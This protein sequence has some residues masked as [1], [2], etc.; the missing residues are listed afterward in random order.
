MASRASSADSAPR[1]E[2]EQRVR[3]LLRDLRVDTGDVVLF[4][5]KC[6]SMGLYGGAI[7]V[8]AKFFGR[9]Q[10]DHNGVVVRA[11]S[12]APAAAGPED[13]LFVLEAALT[14]VKLR[15]LVARVLLSRGH[16]VAVRKL[17]VERSPELQH[18][19]LQFAIG[20]LNAPYEDN[21]ARFFNAGVSVPTRIARERIFA[22]LVATKKELARLD[23]EL[24]HRDK[25]PAF[26]R[27]A[28]LQEHEAVNERYHALGAELRGRERSVFE[29]A[30][31]EG[32]QVKTTK[33][34]CSQLVAGLYQHLGL[35]LP[36]PSANSYLPKHFSARDGGDFLKLQQGASFLPEI[37][38]RQ[39]LEKETNKYATRTL[40][41]T[42]RAPRAGR[43]T[44]AIVHCLR[45]HQLFHTLSEPELLATASQF[46]RRVL[47]KGEVVFYQGAPGDCFYI[48][49][50]GDCDVF[51]DYDHLL[52]TQT[53]LHAAD[54]DNAPNPELHRRMMLRKRK[55]IAL[56][57]FKSSSSLVGKNE[58]V[59]VATNGP[60]N[61]FGESALIYDTPRRAT[62]QASASNSGDEDEAVVLWQLDKRT[63]REILACHPGSQQ[64]LEERRFLLEALED[65]PLFTELDDRAK[66]LA[67]RKCFPLSVRAGTTILRQ[68]DPGDYFYLV[69][70]G[71][72]E[73]S[74]RKPKATKPFVDRVIGRGASFGE[75]ALLYNSRRGAS[76]KAL[77]DAKIWCMDRASFLTITRSGSTALHKLFR[78]VGTTVVSGSN[79]SFATER[80]LRRMLTDPQQMQL[81]R[82]SANEDEDMDEKGEQPALHHAPLPSPQAY[83]RAVQLALSLLL[84]DSSGLVN[85]SQF[86]H[87]HIALGAANIDQLLP[88]AA[89]RVLKSVTDSYDGVNT[90]IPT[91]S[92]SLFDQDDTDQAVIKLN[93]LPRAIHQ[94]ISTSEAAGAGLDNLEAPVQM[95]PGRLAFYE[96]LFDLPVH[97]LGDQYATHDD[98]VRGIAAFEVEDVRSGSEHDGDHPQSADV[99]AAKEEFR[100]FLVALKAD[101]DS[102]RTIWRA[103]ELQ[104][105]GGDRGD[106]KNDQQRLTFDANLKSGWISA[107]RQN[108]TGGDWEYLQPEMEDS[109]RNSK[110]SATLRRHQLMAQVTSFAAAIAA[111]ALART[112]CAPLERLKMLMQL[113]T[114]KPTSSAAATATKLLSGSAPYTSLTRGFWNMVKVSGPRSL[115]SGNL[116][117][118]IWVVPS[119]PTK[120]VLCHFYQEQLARMLPESSSPFGAPGVGSPLVSA[121]MANLAVGGLAGLTLNCLFYPLDVVRGRLTVQQYYNANRPSTGIL[122]CA[123]S[124]R[125]KEGLRGFYRGFVPASLGVFTYIGC[126]FALYESLRPVF[127]LYD[128][129]DTSNQL[130][131]P[132]VPGQ[133]LCATTA[134]LGSQCISYPFDVI[135][136]R[137]QLQGAKWHLE[138]AFPTYES[139]WDCVRSSIQQEGGGVRGL[140]SLYRGLFVNAVKAL[141]STII[142]FLSYEKL[143]ETRDA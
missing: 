114:P 45:R 87:F 29:N 8:C 141:P 26:E 140:R 40:E 49:E 47:A 102:L 138:L 13:E 56:P 31:V 18:K 39:A 27:K 77:E 79:E 66:A 81:V 143:R 133:I 128:T 64:S 101:I 107:L 109:S 90:R 129:E 121:S 24:A 75:A 7:C 30:V 112:V 53:A 130:G 123:R 10:W 19:A 78:K 117:H 118:C 70:S 132:S 21:P 105:H 136:R 68:G 12:L 2:D 67:V 51:V 108:P 119:V 48:I 6:S 20:S 42:E 65:H 60:G 100:A 120:F 35:L 97:Q 76:V 54:S 33:M 135:R 95:T 62:I 92:S 86:A 1:S 9:T 99:T 34:F 5:R 134:S 43:E 32:N 50:R 3:Q 11:P 59:H 106:M 98:L 93:D 28:L 126:N 69:E 125:D 41:A 115:F 91:P 22:A 57:E 72:C 85:F 4:D 15:P 137:V 84:N 83:D 122:D 80:D 17:Q 124:I 94:W 52:K 89:F 63:F 111:G 116:A 71:R 46:R 16:E 25:M 73:V 37:S 131:H 23:A 44:A 74:R 38:L 55:T 142:S 113:S 14:G 58:R 36:Y 103:A 127:V 61:A 110:I 88:E 139:A 96:R 104:A 82:H